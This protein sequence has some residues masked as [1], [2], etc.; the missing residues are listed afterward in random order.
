MA[1]A[2][3]VWFADLSMVCAIFV[4]FLPIFEL[5]PLKSASQPKTFK[6]RDLGI[7]EQNQCEYG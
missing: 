4:S 1:V 2:G 6:F 7:V 5:L 3:S